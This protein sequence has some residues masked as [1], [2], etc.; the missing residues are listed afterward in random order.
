MRDTFPRL[1]GSPPYRQESHGHQ[2]K[3]A[4]ANGDQQQRALLISSARTNQIPEVQSHGTRAKS[5]TSAGDGPQFSIQRQVQEDRRKYAQHREA[6]SDQQIRRGNIL[7]TRCDQD[8]DG[9]QNSRGTRILPPRQKANYREAA[10]QPDP[11]AEGKENPKYDSPGE[12]P[13]RIDQQRLVNI[14]HSL[15]FSYI[16]GAAWHAARRWHRR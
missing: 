4:K 6:K 9:T 2:C 7:I 13:D 5:I 8:S 1:S 14:R 15:V 10:R 12:M 11:A 16:C 3:K